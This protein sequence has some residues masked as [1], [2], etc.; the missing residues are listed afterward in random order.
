MTSSKNILPALSV[1]KVIL[2]MN[3]TTTMSAHG[4]TNNTMSAFKSHYLRTI[5]VQIQFDAS[6]S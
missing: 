6:I 1:N 3:A 4:M 5:A 2:K